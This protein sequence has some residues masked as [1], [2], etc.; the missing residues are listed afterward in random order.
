MITVYFDGKCGLCSKEIR[1]YQGIAPG[2]V[3]I[4]HD[5]ATDP[6]PLD[7]FGVDQASALRWLHARDSAGNWHI[8]VAAF[9]LIWRHLP[10]WRWLAPVVE[11]PVVLPIAQ[12]GYNRFADYRFA[13]LPHCQVFVEKP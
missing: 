12:W 11:L 10:Y 13:R 8:G 4:W 3:F 1:Y 6:A 9:T 7:E 5:I 2:E